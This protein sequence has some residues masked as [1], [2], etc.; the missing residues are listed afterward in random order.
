MSERQTTIRPIK[1]LRSSRWTG[2]ADWGRV[3]AEDLYQAMRKHAEQDLKRAQELLAMTR[4]DFHVETHRGVIRQ[5]SVQEVPWPERDEEIAK[6]IKRRTLS[7]GDGSKVLAHRPGIYVHPATGDRYRLTGILGF[8]SVLSGVFAGSG[9]SGW[10]T[11]WQDLIPEDEWNA[12]Q[13][14]AEQ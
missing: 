11:F 13:K 3:P 5:T 4:E 10:P 2:E 1:P 12:R 9:S 8:Y 14:E 6:S 7:Q